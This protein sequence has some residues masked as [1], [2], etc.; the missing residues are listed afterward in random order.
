[1]HSVALVC[2]YEKNTQHIL[3]EELIII[4]KNGSST[5]C[6][7]LLPVVISMC[8]WSDLK[9]SWNAFACVEKCCPASCVYACASA[10]V[11]GRFAWIKFRIKRQVMTQRRTT[12]KPQGCWNAAMQQCSDTCYLFTF[13]PGRWN[14]HIIIVFLWSAKPFQLAT[15]LTLR[16]S[17]ADHAHIKLDWL[18]PCVIHILAT[19]PGNA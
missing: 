10:S 16:L 7:L 3:V 11:C 17:P 5:T 6:F 9:G 1:M 14:I 18:L 19:L 13:I 15:R 8:S 2:W 4:F 12:R